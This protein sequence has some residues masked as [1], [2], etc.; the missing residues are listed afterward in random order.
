VFKS[1]YKLPV[2]QTNTE[3]CVSHVPSLV[4]IPGR[5]VF[6]Q[7]WYQGGASL[8]DFTDPTKPKE[9]GY[10]DR[11]PISATQLVLGGFWST[12]WYN[13][14]IYASEIARGYDSFGLTPTADLSQAE[15]DAAKRTSKLERFNAQSQDAFTY[16]AP[17]VEGGVGGTVP[18]TLSLTLAAPG[19]F[20][21]FQPGVT[22]TYTTTTDATVTSSAGDALL[23]V[24]DPSSQ[25]TGHLVN[26]TFA[27]PQPLQ[28]RARNAANT[29]TAYNNVGSSASP[30]NLL[31]WSAPISNDAVTLGFSQLINSTD[32]LRTGTYSKTLTFTLSTTSP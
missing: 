5:D 25:N 24:A 22:R 16:N 28:A 12:Y 10:F 27:L 19:Q 17:P 30:L 6:V 9:I 26:G 31:T 32:P 4:P 23:S 3:N 1:Y 11:G 15:I 29:G 7:A 20:G 8:V 13:G 2:A 14:A 21:A 18:A